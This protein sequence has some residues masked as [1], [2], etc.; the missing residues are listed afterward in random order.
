MEFRLHVLEQVFGTL[1]L[2]GSLSDAGFP[3]L[4]MSGRGG[5]RIR[6]SWN[7]N[8]TGYSRQ[9]LRGTTEWVNEGEKFKKEIKCSPTRHSDTPP[10]KLGN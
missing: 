3:L 9:V 5:R 4:Y 8:S 1:N 6:V 7:E 10:L 2:F